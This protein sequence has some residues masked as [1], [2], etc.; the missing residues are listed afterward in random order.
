M[1]KKIF[2]PLFLALTAIVTFA[3]ST[4]LNWFSSGNSPRPSDDDQS[5][6]QKINDLL[7]H[8]APVVTNATLVTFNG[9]A[10]ILGAAGIGTNSV[11][12]ASAII[13]DNIPTYVRQI[14]MES[15][16]TNL[17]N[18]G[19]DFILGGVVMTKLGPG[20]QYVLTSAAGTVFNLQGIF[21]RGLTN[22]TITIVYQQ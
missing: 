12:L 5:S 1:K 7:Y 22:S 15:S 19:I 3:I 18:S 16:S 20:Q 8:G 10:A 17:S 13:G 6:L 11:N 9:K 14:I 2:V 21:V 4:P